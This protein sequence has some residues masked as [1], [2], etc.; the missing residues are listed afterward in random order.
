VSELRRVFLIA[1]AALS[2]AAAPGTVRAS[3]GSADPATLIALKSGAWCTKGAALARADGRLIAPELGLW[4][5]P[6]GRGAD[7]VP[8]LR[9]SGAIEFVQ[10]ELVYTVSA[11]AD[12]ADP[13]VST[14]WWR[15]VVGVAD[16]TPPGPGVPVSLVDSGVSFGHPEFA[17]RPDLIA[18]N[19][20]E[21]APLGGV[22]GTSVASVIGA[23]ANG[24]GLVGIYPQAVIR[25]YDAAIG[26]GTQL[27]TSQIVS[28]ILSAVRTG[29]SVINL[30]LGGNRRDAAVESAVNQAVRSGSLVVAASGNSGNV[31]N[32][33]SYPAATPHVLTV[34]AV[35]RSGQAAFFS[36]RSPHV[37]LAAPGVDIPVASALDG[38]YATT[39]GTSFAA[40][41][42]SG[43]AAWLW[44]VRPELDAGQVAEILRR[45]ARD[46]APAGVDQATGYGILNF[47]AAL[48]YPTPQAD[49]GE[50][51][52]DVRLN[53]SAASTLTTRSRPAASASASVT[54]FEDPRD[55]VR[56]WIPAG[57]TIVARASSVALSLYA[58]SAT[59]V[60][61]RTAASARLA[62]STLR[63]AES[64][65]SFPN[66]KPGRSGYLVVSLPKGGRD[67]NYTLNVSAR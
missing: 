55:V 53:G 13:L 22:H 3:R 24:L 8:T 6:D 36:S 14:E 4:R 66:G 32:E 1:L 54:V 16:L 42:V 46:V 52:D 29:K 44:T 34:A 20:Q 51:N 17:G 62:R 15:A 31:G 63:G 11:T 60:V 59:T 9:A 35:D 12:F 21:P 47:P 64:V 18:L 43:A 40:P 67:A 26:A 56:V 37:D 38:A 65:L 41:I 45:S 49:P 39:S 33:P 48:A 2:A 5:L 58:G 7:V 10:R 23:P 27:E 61:G 30:S 57:R 28:G 50:P 19:A 25:S